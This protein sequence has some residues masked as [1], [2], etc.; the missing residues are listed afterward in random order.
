MTKEK[1]LSEKEVGVHVGD[2][3]KIFDE[4]REV[5]SVWTTSILLAGDVKKAVEKLKAFIEDKKYKIDHHVLGVFFLSYRDVKKEI[6]K[7]F[8]RFE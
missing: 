2:M 3:K 6:D 4:K 8:G 1:P 7:I 5:G